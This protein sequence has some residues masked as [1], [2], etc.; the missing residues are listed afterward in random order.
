MSSSLEAP[1][2][3][4]DVVDLVD[5][6]TPVGEVQH[7]VVHVGVEVT[8]P[9]HDLLNAPVAPPRPVVRREQDLGFLAV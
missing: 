1:G 5:R 6:H 8:L 2:Q 9:T 7:L 3:F 4:V